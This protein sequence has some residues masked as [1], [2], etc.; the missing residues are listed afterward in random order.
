MIVKTVKFRNTLN[1]KTAYVSYMTAKSLLLSLVPGNLVENATHGS[2]S[3]C[4]GFH[5]A[6]VF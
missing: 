6:S 1:E 5:G 3:E 2:V 4:K